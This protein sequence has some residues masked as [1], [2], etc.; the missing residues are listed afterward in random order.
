[1]GLLQLPTKPCKQTP[2]PALWEPVGAIKTLPAVLV[3]GGCRFFPAWGGVF[4][5]AMSDHASP[6]YTLPGG[7]PVKR[8]P[9][10][11]F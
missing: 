6:D 9:H 5:L 1:M 8:Q 7:L 3:G 11:L 2:P 4:L 10:F